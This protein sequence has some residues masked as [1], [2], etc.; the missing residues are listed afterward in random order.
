M[1]ALQ[2]AAGQRRSSLTSGR[3]P[4]PNLQYQVLLGTAAELARAS[5]APAVENAGFPGGGAPGNA[6]PAGLAPPSASGLPAVEG[7]LR[8][9]WSP[10][11]RAQR[12]HCWS[13]PGPAVARGAPAPGC[14][15]ER[16][17]GAA[18]R[19]RREALA[20]A[21]VAVGGRR[22]RMRALSHGPGTPRG[23]R[24]L[25]RAHACAIL[26]FPRP[27]SLSEP[28]RRVRALSPADRSGRVPSAPGPR[29]SPPPPS[30]QAARLLPLPA[31][32]GRRCSGSRARDPARARSRAVSDCPARAASR[33]LSVTGA[34]GSVK[35]RRW[36]LFPFLPL[37]SVGSSILH[38]ATSPTPLAEGSCGCG[39]GGGDRGAA[40]TASAPA[41]D[42]SFC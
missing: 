5:P 19:G 14:C 7:G 23:A 39:C 30:P 6:K 31:E 4:A 10:R 8:S 40:E 21:W 13:S 22:R 33:S 1:F 17:K 18:K 25:P 41:S 37:P 16:S 15:G 3:E 11:P 36:F 9:L 28:L 24:P 38:P 42:H 34:G 32:W 20:H 26:G 12:L 27:L 2:A 35:R 29:P